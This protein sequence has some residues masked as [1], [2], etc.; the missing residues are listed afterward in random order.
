MKTGTRE[1][2]VLSEVLR[3]SACMIDHYNLYMTGC[4]DQQLRTILDRQQR[5]TLD[6]FQR[7]I[8]M[9]QSHGLD[10]SNIPLPTTMPVTAGGAQTTGAAQYG[11]QWTGR[12]Y[13]QQTG[14][15]SYSP[16]YTAGSPG[17]G[18]QMTAGQPGTQAPT[19]NDRIISEGALLFHKFGAEI[20]TRAALKSSEPH[21]RNALTNMARNCIEMS[22]ELYNYMSQRG[23]YQLPTTPQNFVTH[24]P[25]Q[26]QYPPQ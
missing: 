6:S 9:M 25:T 23:W 21:I 24:S 1:A 7:L 19:F 11:T 18:A 5:H 22:Y 10:T 15:A 20:N 2:M 13:G 16:Q 26:Q 17:V 8:Q 12:Q 14:A 4:Q 3:S